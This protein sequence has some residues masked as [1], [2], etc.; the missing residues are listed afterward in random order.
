MWP[1]KWTSAPLY[2]KLENKVGVLPGECWCGIRGGEQLAAV[3]PRMMSRD[4][5]AD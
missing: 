2:G 4:I 3:I 5:P 1:I